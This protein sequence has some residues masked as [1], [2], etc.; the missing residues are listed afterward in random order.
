MAV[1]AEQQARLERWES[2]LKSATTQTLTTDYTRPDPP[3][4]VEAVYTAVLPDK[5]RLALLQLGI[6]ETEE[7]VTP[8]TALLTAYAILASK[9]TGDE[10][11][12]LG[13]SNPESEPFIVRTP[14]DPKSTFK[15]ILERVQ[16]VRHGRKYIRI[17]LMF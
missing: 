4:V 6:I 12:S 2:R 7:A 1:D 14:V 13:T 10:D 3:R 15:N 9:L 8:F 17:H 16:K 5:I 11:I